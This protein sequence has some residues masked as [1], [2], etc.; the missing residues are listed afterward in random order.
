MGDALLATCERCVGSNK[1][2]LSCQLMAYILSWLHCLHSHC[3]CIL[4]CCCACFQPQHVSHLRKSLSTA[5]GQRPECCSQ[6]PAAC[7]LMRPSSLLLLHSKRLPHP[8]V[9]WHEHSP[10][11]GVLRWMLCCI[12]SA[13]ARQPLLILSQDLPPLLIAVPG[14]QWTGTAVNIATLP[15]C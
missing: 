7:L 2:L 3:R 6:K 8:P 12:K 14:L 1:G 4:E 15:S 10:G 13:Y 9:H 5:A 11:T